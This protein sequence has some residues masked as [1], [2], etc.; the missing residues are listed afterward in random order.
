MI[1]GSMIIKKR[2]IKKGY[3]MI[4]QL[5][6]LSMIKLLSFLFKLRELLTRAQQELLEM[7]VS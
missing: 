2:P 7:Q 3:T 5:L 6:A 4:S 1:D